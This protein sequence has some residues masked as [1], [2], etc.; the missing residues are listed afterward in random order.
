MH[1]GGL[2]SIQKA[3]MVMFYRGTTRHILLEG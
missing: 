3:F 1:R 2:I